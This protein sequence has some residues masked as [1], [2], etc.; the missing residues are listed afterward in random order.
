MNSSE[1]QKKRAFQ[2]KLFRE[3]S[4]YYNKKGRSGAEMISFEDDDGNIVPAENESDAKVIYEL[5]S[6][7][8]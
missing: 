5:A 1:F 2:N 4:E 8:K 3:S 6:K 7:V